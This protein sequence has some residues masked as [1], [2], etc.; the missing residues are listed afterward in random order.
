MAMALTMATAMATTTTTATA[1]ATATVNQGSNQR[2]I[3]QMYNDFNPSLKKSIP[4][5]AASTSW[6]VKKQKEKRHTSHKE[7][8][9]EVSMTVDNAPAKLKN[10]GLLFTTTSSIID[11][12]NTRKLTCSNA[13]YFKLGG[14]MCHILKQE[15]T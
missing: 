5:G 1:T 3:V 9:K 12:I 2:L 13:L 4:R 14:S 10:Q 15:T 7:C 6:Q 11:A 8:T